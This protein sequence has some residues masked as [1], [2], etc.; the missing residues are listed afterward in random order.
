[1][2]SQATTEFLKWTLALVGLG[3]VAVGLMLWMMSGSAELPV[4]VTQEPERP[5]ASRGVQVEPRVPAS[6]DTPEDQRPVVVNDQE[7]IP[8]KR[9]ETPAVVSVDEEPRESDEVSHQP[10]VGDDADTLN[11]KESTNAL[12]SQTRDASESSLASNVGLDDG[13]LVAGPEI[14]PLDS[15]SPPVTM[16]PAEPLDIFPADPVTLRVELHQAINK[17]RV[18]NYRQLWDAL[19]YTDQDPDRPGYVLLFYTGW[20][21][22]AQM[23]GGDPD[24][25]NREHV[26]VKSRGDFGNRPGPGTDL[27]HIRA[28]DVSV[29][30]ARGNLSFDEGGRLYRD[31]DGPTRCRRDD[32]SWEPDDPVKGDVARMM[33]YMDVRYESGLD[34]ELVDAI[35]APNDK[36]PVHGKLSTLLRWHEL[37]PVDEAERQRN[38][39]I[40]ELQGNRNPFIDRPQLARMLWPTP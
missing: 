31:G 29:N 15:S 22:S 28:T 1:M 21:R 37:D 12:P 19:I 3:V 18:L 13:P 40:E 20:S 27:H 2:A 30:G 17:H 35:Q 16:M 25:W 6:A 34:L 26:W 10:S 33:F 7:A 38:D 9:D 5:A 8:P 4:D 11:P 14:Q 23:N 39:R 24:E 36:S 32:D